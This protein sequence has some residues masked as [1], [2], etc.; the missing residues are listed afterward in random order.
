VLH[1]ARWKYRTQKLWKKSPSAHHSTTSSGYIFAIK[2]C[3]NNRKKIAKQQYLPHNMVNVGL[4]G[5]DRLVSLGHPANFNV[6]HVLASLLH[7]CRSTEL[8]LAL[9]DVW[10][11]PGLVHYIYIVGGLASKTHFTPP[12]PTRQNCFVGSESVVWNRFNGIL[13]GAKFTLPP[14]LAFS[15]IVRVAVRHSSSV[16]QPN[17]AAWY[18]HTTGRSSRLTLGGWTVYFMVA[19][20]I[21]QTIYIFILSF[22]L[23]S[24]FFPRLISAVVDWMSATLPHMVWL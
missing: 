1:A 6:F 24:S 3:I 9:H 5:W 4:N 7:R 11:F 13:P 21:G 16:R 10:P 18:L 17:F 12:T 2:A 8:N 22:V 19:Y 15:Y 14:S 20:V 23:F